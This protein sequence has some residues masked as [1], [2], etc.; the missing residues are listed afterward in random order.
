MPGKE[1]GIVTAYEISNLDLS[2][3]ELVVLSAC[4]TAL[5]DIRGTEGVF[6]LQRSFKLAG[7]QQMILSLWQVPDKETVELMSIFYANK[8]KGLATYDAFNAAQE[9]MRK[10]YS[11]YFWAAFILVE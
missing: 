9:T 8:L 2:S 6:G 10:K 4:E 1:D 5:G 7:V 3:T 11:P